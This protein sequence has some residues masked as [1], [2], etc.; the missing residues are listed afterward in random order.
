M[1]SNSILGCGPTSEKL[2]NYKSKGEMEANGWRF[3][4]NSEHYQFNAGRKDW[5]GKGSHVGYVIGGNSGW[6]EIT[7]YGSG[8]VDV[9]YA[10]G[11]HEGRVDVLLNDV[12]KQHVTGYRSQS[13]AHF[14][15]ND[16]DVLR[17]AEGED[18][19]VG[20]LVL[21]SIQ[22]TCG[23]STTGKMFKANLTRLLF[24]QDRST[25]KTVI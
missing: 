15:F 13:I 3:G 16:G 20:V 6:M 23:D 4:W 2:N 10:S 21:N 1:N 5:M 14:S 17:I 19:K 7:L 9:D 25:R 24:V 11:H 18:G 8:Q 12:T 22:L